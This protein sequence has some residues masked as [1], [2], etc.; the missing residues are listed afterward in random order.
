M[1]ELQEALL[2]SSQDVKDADEIP[3]A[4]NGENDERSEVQRLPTSREG[5]EQKQQD[6]NLFRKF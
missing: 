1:M 4:S 2:E 6:L 5:R 3:S